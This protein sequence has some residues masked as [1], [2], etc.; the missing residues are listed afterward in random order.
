[1][2]VLYHS[3]KPSLATLSTNF[4]AT[5]IFV[6]RFEDLWAIGRQVLFFVYEKLEYH[7]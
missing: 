4:F 5:T 6:L 7:I 3:E 2:I 1:M